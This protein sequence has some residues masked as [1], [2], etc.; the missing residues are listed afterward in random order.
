[1]N[2]IINTSSLVPPIAGIGRYTQELI[3]C[4]LTDTR[5]DDIRGFNS[6]AVFD[7]QALIEL[8]EET[9]QRSPN[10]TL[11][12]LKKVLRSMPGL[13]TLRSC[14]QQQS[15]KKIL[16]NYA[17]AVL[18]EPNYVLQHHDGP[19]IATLHDLSYLRYPQ[20]H[21]PAMIA[22]LN[23]QLPKTIERATAFVTLSEFSK[24]ELVQALNIDPQ[25]IHIIPPAVNDVYQIK[26]SA[27]QIQQVKQHYGLPDRYVLTVSTLEP[28]K[29]INGLIAAFSRLPEALKSQYPLVIVGA[30]GWG[31]QDYQ[32]RYQKLIANNQL[33]FMGYVAQDDLPFIYQ[34]AELFAFLSFYEGYGMPIAEAMASGVAVLAS[35][36]A[37]MPE[38][39][40]DSAVLVPPDD[41]D[42]IQVALAT[43][44][45]SPAQREQMT[46]KGRNIAKD[47]TWQKSA[48]LLIEL[49]Q[50]IDQSHGQ[51]YH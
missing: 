18:W 28:R 31:K 5:V 32:Q 27:E 42:A 15:Y 12:K 38:V 37:S 44:L 45:E 29:N 36:Q 50:S 24:T 43:L 8:I 13:Y 33:Y 35:N 3:K 26:A 34:A 1:M 10:Q 11:I 16:K 40:Q 51:K 9:S 23:K 17:D 41:S 39:A 48:N 30:S 7:R 25:K 49:C 19:S 20:H 22:W 21:H 14:I 4:L 6:T 46:Q 47:Y 2:L